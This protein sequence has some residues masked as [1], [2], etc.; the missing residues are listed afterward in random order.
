[1]WWFISSMAMSC[2]IVVV[3]SLVIVVVISCFSYVQV[4]LWWFCLWSLWWLSPGHCGGY[5]RFCYDLWWLSPVFIVVVISG[6][7]WLSP[8][9]LMSNFQCGGL[10]TVYSIVVVIVEI[11]YLPLIQRA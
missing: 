6:L 9:Y 10:S 8:V 3:L 4:L 11:E 5:L 1:M 2:K 7:W